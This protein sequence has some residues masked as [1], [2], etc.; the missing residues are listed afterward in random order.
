MAAAGCDAALA[1]E[2]LY[3]VSILPGV[4]SGL[5]FAANPPPGLY[6]VDFNN[7]GE[8]RFS[9]RGSAAGLD[10]VS[11]KTSTHSLVLFWSSPFE[12]LGGRFTTFAVGSWSGVYLY[13]NG[14]RIADVRGW[15]NPGVAPSISW[16]LGQGWFVRAGAFVWA[17]AGTMDKGP[18]GN[19]LGNIGAPYWTIEPN[20]AVS[21]LADGWNLTAN[22]FYGISTRNPYSGVTNG[23][24]LN[25]DWTATKKFNG[26]ELGPVG[27]VSTQVTGDRGCES[28]YGPNVCAPGAKAGVGGLVGYDFGV[29]HARLAVTGSVYN[30]NA[31]DGWR[32]WTSLTFGLPHK[33]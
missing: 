29:V 1:Y 24:S 33:P 11:Y 22:L 10:G 5:P 13:D 25:L 17:P 20:V 32:V 21:Y 9:G 4:T 28:F 7:G 23:H 14:N 15:H 26:V 6:F 19:G 31:F 18:V 27:Y 2:P 8:G 3:V 12:V 16:E 30:H